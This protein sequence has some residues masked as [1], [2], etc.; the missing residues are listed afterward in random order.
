VSREVR[1]RNSKRSL[2]FLFAASLAIAGLLTTVNPASATTYQ[3]TPLL[4]ADNAGAGICIYVNAEAI[5]PSVTGTTLDHNEYGWKTIRDSYWGC[6]SGGTYTALAN[7]ELAI[8]TYLRRTSDNATCQSTSQ[9]YIPGG[10]S[11]GAIG[12]PYTTGGN[13]SGNYYWNST[14]LDTAYEPFDIHCN[15]GGNSVWFSA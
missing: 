9:W 3:G 14:C 11:W 4:L 5:V 8:A 1:H 10:N 12:E 7:G 15:L 2:R 13:C 6:S